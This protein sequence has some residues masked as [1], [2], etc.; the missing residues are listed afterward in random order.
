[1][2]SDSD[3]QVWYRLGYLLERAR[4]SPGDARDTLGDLVERVRDVIPGGKKDQ[5]RKSPFPLPEADQIVA[6]GLT[7]V[8]AKLLSAW[9][10]S[11]RTGV[12]DLLRAALTGAGAAVVVELARPLLRGE[13]ALPELDDGTFDRVLAGVAQGLVY[14]AVVE[15]RVPGPGLLRGAVYGTAEYAAVPLGGLSKVFGRATPQGRI[16]MVGR[17]LEG[18]D[19]RERS[20]LEHL[21]FGAVMGALYGTDENSGT[22]FEL[23]DD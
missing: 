18:P 21:A 10:P 4:E 17:L 11:H 7:A 16:P 20:F 3:S 1:M 6:A 13:R 5:G 2:S 23:L 19:G 9:R 22:V 12:G 14:A 8:A 15:P